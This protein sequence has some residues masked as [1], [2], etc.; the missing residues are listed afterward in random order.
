MKETTLMAHL[1]FASLL[2]P[3]FVSFHYILD[4][5]ICALFLLPFILGFAFSLYDL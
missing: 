3:H 4:C 5:F 2:G 1:G